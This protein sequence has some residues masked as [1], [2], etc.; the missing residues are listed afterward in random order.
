[1]SLHPVK[2]LAPHSVPLLVYGVLGAVLIAVPPLAVGALSPGEAYVIAAALAILGAVTGAPYAALVAV[3]TLPLVWAGRGGYA[4][5]EAVVDGTATGWIAVRHVV[6]GGYALAS[7]SVGS[8]L[9]GAEL[10]GLPLPAGVAVPS[11]VIV[12]GLLTGASFAALQSWRYR[13][14][15]VP[16]DP[17]TTVETV[18]LGALL[19]LAPAVAY[20]RFGGGLGGL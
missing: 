1:V 15:G 13:P 8:A 7:A 14:L 19:A 5:P 17:K 6:G 18:A 2:R 11:G 16:L 9:V 3:G 10:A 4:S 12:G 20:W